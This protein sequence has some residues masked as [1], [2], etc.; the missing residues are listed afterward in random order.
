MGI[1]SNIYNA[2]VSTTKDVDIDVLTIPQERVLNWTE[3]IEQ[4][5]TL[6]EVRK[7]YL[8]GWMVEAELEY[9]ES[10]QDNAA[11]GFPIEQWNDFLL[12]KIERTPKAPWRGVEMAQE[13]GIL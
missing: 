12:A 2:I 7:T 9:K 3:T 13:L 11:M 4:D 1:V 6:S 10:C 5:K 8:K